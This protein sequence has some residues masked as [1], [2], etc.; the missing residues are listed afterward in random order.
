MGNK[1]VMPP[2][3]V[4]ELTDLTVSTCIGTKRVKRVNERKSRSER[5][6]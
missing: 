1:G 5:S 6:E 3:S 2:P 4:S